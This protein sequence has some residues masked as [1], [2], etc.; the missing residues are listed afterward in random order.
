MAAAEL[1]ALVSYILSI[2]F[3]KDIF[4][5]TDKSIFLWKLFDTSVSKLNSREVFCK[6]KLTYELS[7]G[8]RFEYSIV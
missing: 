3:F 1:F 4:G 6:C 7:A 8:K 2:I 5:K